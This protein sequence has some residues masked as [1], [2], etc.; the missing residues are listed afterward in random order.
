MLLLVSRIDPQMTTVDAIFA[1]A[2]LVLVVVE[3]FADQ[4]QWD[5]HQAK[6][7]YQTTAKVRR[8]LHQIPLSAVLIAILH[9]RYLKAG[10]E[11]KWTADSTPL[12]C[13]AGVGIR[14]LPL[15]RRSGSYSTLGAV[16]N[17]AHPTIGPVAV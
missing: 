16:I 7:S 2:L 14:T 17:Q 10:Q 12:V 6:N 4:Q 3:Y 5:F 8:A 9:C 13:G 1:R 15:S 11:R